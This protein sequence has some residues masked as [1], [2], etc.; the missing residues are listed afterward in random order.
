MVTLLWPLLMV[1]VRV[2]PRVPVPV[3]RLRLMIV[4]EVTLDGLPLASRERTMTEKPVSAT[5]FAPPL[6]DVIASWVAT[7]AL[8]VTLRAVRA[9]FAVPSVAVNVA[10][11]TDDWTVTPPFTPDP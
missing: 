4:F 2:P 1:P 3:L 11:P 10:V 8:T 7:P 9:V 5:G 6:I